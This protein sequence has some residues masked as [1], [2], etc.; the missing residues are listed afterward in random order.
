MKVQRRPLIGVCH[1]QQQRAGYPSISLVDW[2]V[3]FDIISCFYIAF[4][5]LSKFFFFFVY[6]VDVDYIRVGSCC[7]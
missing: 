3:S 4:Y 7:V 6:S 1:Q 2:V 5:S